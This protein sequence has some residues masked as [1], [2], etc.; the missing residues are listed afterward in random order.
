[1]SDATRFYFEALIFKTGRLALL[2]IA[3][4]RFALVS[5]NTWYKIYWLISCRVAPRCS[6]LNVL[7][8]CYNFKEIP[9]DAWFSIHKDIVT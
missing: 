5:W 4:R 8:Q 1:M 9:N 7:L 2:R 6:G 3:S